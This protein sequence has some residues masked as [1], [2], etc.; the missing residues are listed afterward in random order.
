MLV[1]WL[2]G[3]RKPRFWVQRWRKDPYFVVYTPKSEVRKGYMDSV[4]FD[5]ELGVARGGNAVYAS[6]EDVHRKHGC[7]ITECGVYEV[8]VKFRKVVV[9]EK[10][11]VPDFDQEC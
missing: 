7:T 10:R 2:R 3:F 5:H 4:A 8:E 11:Y 6:V 9:P 1:L